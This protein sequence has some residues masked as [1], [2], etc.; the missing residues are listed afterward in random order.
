MMETMWRDLSYAVRRLLRT[1][2]FTAVAVASLALGIGANATIFG[3]VEAVLLRESPRDDPATLVEVYSSQ[4][5]FSHGT[6]SYP[7]VLDLQERTGDA[8]EGVAAFRLS[9]FPHEGDGGEVTMRTAQVVTGNFFTLQGIDAALGR[10]LSPAD[11]RVGGPEPVVVLGHS[12][13]R[14]ELGGDPDVVGRTLRIA[15]RE[16]EVVGVVE[17]AFE[18]SLTGLVPD[19]VLGS[20]LM[21][22]LDARQAGLD[23]R[24]MQSW[25]TTARLLPGTGLAEARGVLERETAWLREAAPEAWRQDKALLGVPAPDVVMN[26]MVDRIMIPALG[27]LLAVVAVVL[28]IACANLASFLL[29]RAA[30]RRRE[31]AVRLALGASRGTLVRQLL[32]ESVLLALL[33]GLAG[34]GV[35]HLAL[36]WLTRADLPLPFPIDLQLAVNGPVLVYALGAALVAGVL[37]GLAPALQATHPDLAGT[38]RT[39]TTGGRRR[40]FSLRNVLVAGQVAASMVLLVGAAL[41]VRSAQERQGVDPG[42]GHRSAAL[43]QLSLS[44]AVAEGDEARAMAEMVDHLRR[45]EGV[46]ALGTTTNMHLDPANTSSRFVRVDGVA[47]PPESDAWEVSFAWVDGG[48]F[49]AAGIDRVEGRLL[50]D[51]DREGARRALVVNRAFAETFFADGSAVGRTVRVGDDEHTVVGVVETVKARSLAEAPRPFIYGSRLQSDVVFAWVVAAV[52]PGVDPRTLALRLSRAGRELDPGLRVYTQTTMERHLAVVQLPGRLTALAGSAFALLAL[53]LAAVGLYGVVS[54]AVASRSREVGIRMS[55]GAEGREV[56]AMLMGGGLKLVAVGAAVGGLLSV[57]F[58]HLLSRFLFGV[59]ALDPLAFGATGAVL[60]AVA[61]LAAWIP[62]RRA[63]RVD[64][65]RALRA[66]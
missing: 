61:V 27:L 3:F 17:P 49:P 22:L 59:A 46:A 7:D 12:F 34:L 43:I 33:G 57:A 37:F 29:A 20:R 41:L 16:L 53:I 54:Y 10:T 35:A 21:A 42:F 13:W 8:F 44:D 32:T 40:P 5:G 56:V 50:D 45:V 19:L 18:G 63:T 36:G 51:S 55:L 26:P 14:N 11:D 47:P 48:F 2:G 38:I 62:A 66:D 30:D 4:P 31:V 28:L 65:V 60:V 24:G 25:F 52:R 23:S 64:P 39:E 9:M 15:G 1:P 58:A 6:L